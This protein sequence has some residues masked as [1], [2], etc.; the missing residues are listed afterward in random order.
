MI[1][2]ALLLFSNAFSPISVTASPSISDGTVTY[3]LF[4]VYD[5][6]LIVPSEF[7]T[8]VNAVPSSSLTQ[9]AYKVTS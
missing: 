9:L 6:I 4:P 2:L 5:V 8:Y 7:F 3:L 1:D